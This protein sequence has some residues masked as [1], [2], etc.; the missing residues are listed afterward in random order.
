ML[1]CCVRP[2]GAEP[3]ERGLTKGIT[4]ASTEDHGS[5]DAESKARRLLT[6][7]AWVTRRKRSLSSFSDR[8]ADKAGL[9]VEKKPPPMPKLPLTPA[10]P[11]TRRHSEASPSLSHIDETWL[12]IRG[13]AVC[14]QFGLQRCSFRWPIIKD[15]L[16]DGTWLVIRQGCVI[17]PVQ[18]GYKDPLSDGPFSD[19]LGPK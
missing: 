19:H 16:S 12:M 10:I 3:Y 4:P 11:L 9:D 1:Y 5:R 18:F 7:A 6:N 2:R 8:W 17:C 14:V 13:D 15:A